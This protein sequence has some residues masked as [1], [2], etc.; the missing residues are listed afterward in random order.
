MVTRDGIITGS[1]VQTYLRRAIFLLIVIHAFEL[2]AQSDEYTFVTNNLAT[3][4]F[5]IDAKGEIHPRKRTKFVP[6]QINWEFF[7][8]AESKTGTISV[9]DGKTFNISDRIV[10]DSS[11]IPSKVYIGKTADNNQD[12]LIVFLFKG[13]IKTISLYNY[14]TKKVIHC[15]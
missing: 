13:D 4:N 5:S 8:N 9:K 11:E 12:V 6:V 15:Y 1:V 2:R 14:A 7:V 3:A 10:R